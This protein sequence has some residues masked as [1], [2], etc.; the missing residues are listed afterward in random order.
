MKGT[1]NIDKNATFRVVID[2]AAG[3]YLEIK[4]GGELSLAYDS[5]GALRLN[6]TYKFTDGFYQM[7]FYNIVKK[8][9]KFQ[10]G[11]SITWNGDPMNA[12]MDITALYRIETSP[13]ALMLSGAASGNNPALNRKLPFEVVMNI[14]GEL[15]KPVLTFD[16]RLAQSA[17]GAMGGAITSRLNQLRKNE[18]DMNKQV[19]ALL[20][21]NSFLGPGGGEQNVV[22]GQARSSASQILTQQLNRLG[23]NVKG[24]DINFDLDSYGG[25]AG[26]GNTDLSVDL[27][28]SLLNNRVIVRVGSTVALENNQNSGSDSKEMMTNI[29][30]EYKI[31]P[32]GRYRFK[33]FRE[34]DF[35]NIVIGRIT[36]SGAGLLFQRDFNRLNRLFEKTKPPPQ[37]EEEENPDSSNTEAT[38]Q[39]DSEK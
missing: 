29:V 35:E 31:T 30:I 18:S 36:R 15:E 7:T 2:S 19:F 8:Q 25:A 38:E 34:T 1:L 21:L 33:A 26:E 17:K 37:E 20:V 12:N 22:A 6:G 10:E 13:A 24:V 39:T 11:S 5:T 27:E 23:D 32:D 9:S 28:K 16:I 4:G 14:A 3:D